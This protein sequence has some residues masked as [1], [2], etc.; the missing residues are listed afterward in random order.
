[1]TA[2]TVLICAMLCAALLN[3]GS[4][5]GALFCSLAAAAAAA[6]S[7]ST[8]SL[9]FPVAGEPFVVAAGVSSCTS[10]I[11]GSRALLVAQEDVF[12][13]TFDFVWSFEDGD[14]SK[15][16]PVEFLFLVT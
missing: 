5:F 15:L 10:D 2:P 7:V 16:F 9:P 12:Y 6:A 14:I 4:C 1:M 11:M 3:L 8:D 13:R